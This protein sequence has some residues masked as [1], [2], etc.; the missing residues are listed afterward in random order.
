MPNSQ[1]YAQGN[2][3]S[4]LDHVPSAKPAKAQLP[5]AYSVLSGRL[6][7]GAIARTGLSQKEAMTAL[8]FE[9]KGGFSEALSGRR[10]IGIHRLMRQEA[11]GILRE[12][13]ILMS[14]EQGMC[15]VERVVRFKEAI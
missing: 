13:V 14:L 6:L 4:D 11:A 15:E 2:R 8:G 9:H 12:F 3:V 7:R 1:S 10:Q 5:D